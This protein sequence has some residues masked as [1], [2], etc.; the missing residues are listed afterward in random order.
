MTRP[1]DLTS[2]ARRAIQMLRGAMVRFASPDLVLNFVT[3]APNDVTRH[4]LRAV[5]TLGIPDR[6]REGPRAI[7]QLAEE[8]GANH[9]ALERVFAH[10]VRIGLF[11]S[12]RPGVVA[13][14]R[15]SRSRLLSSAE[16]SRAP[17]FHVDGAGPRLE[18]A[19][20]GMLHT[21][22]T[23][24]P[25]YVKVHGEQLWEAMTASEALVSAFDTEME[26]HAHAIVRSL[27]SAYDW[28]QIRHLVD[29]GGGTGHMLVEVLRA[30]PSMR[31]TLVEFAAALDRADDVIRKANLADRC[32]IFEGSFFDPLPTGA[33]AYLLAWVL[34][35][36]SDEKAT[37]LLHR[38]RE[39]AG[40]TGRVLLLEKQH[41]LA[42][43]T[44]LDLRMM[45]FFG[46]RERTTEQYRALGEAS[47]L[48]LID[49]VPID[50]G[51]SLFD[52]RAR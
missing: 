30:T 38:C 16:L 3:G 49:V 44:D 39:A 43:D 29:V 46:G 34:H 42:R 4:A 47:A 27:T 1:L 7:G 21:V 10:L 36:W 18:A 50:Q 31:G 28:S 17:E 5:V 20:A 48:Q 22:S 45:T 9:D 40:S 15:V 2:I 11:A 8:V 33:D 35:D 52:L 23:G 6:L 25:S 19:L 37:Q 14:N 51:F 32:D 41:E 12:P 26:L 24:E 13:L